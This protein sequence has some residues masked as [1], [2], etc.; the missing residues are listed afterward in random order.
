MALM[1]PRRKT[2]HIPVFGS[3]ERVDVTGAGD[4]VISTFTLALAAGATYPEA[5]RIANYAGGLKV[6]KTGTATI[7]QEELLAA[8]QEDLA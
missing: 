2:L 7:Y 4:T 3:T 5:A 8:I 6:M 1:E